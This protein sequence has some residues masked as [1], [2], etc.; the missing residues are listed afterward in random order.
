[1]GNLAVIRN[2]LREEVLVSAIIGNLSDIISNQKN[3]NVCKP[4]LRKDEIHSLVL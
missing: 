2:I 4:D 3:H 1:M